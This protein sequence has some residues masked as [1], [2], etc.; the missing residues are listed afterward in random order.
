MRRFALA[1]V[2]IVL[3]IESVGPAFA[4]RR[5]VV[6]HRPHRA[7]VVIHRGFPLHRRLPVVV[8]RPARR[9]VVVRPAVFLAPVV[10]TAGVVALPPRERLGWE[11]SEM[12]ARDDDW[13]EFTLHVGDRGSKLFL[14]LL[15]RTQLNFAEV[16]YENGD[17]QV[18]DFNEKT[19]G[20]GIYSLLDFPDGRKVS[21]VRMVARAR[22]DEA[23]VTLRM[24]K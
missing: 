11:D 10:W 13:T 9:A 1:L 4:R 12:L 18:V 14:E 24:A 16:V 23:K 15:G 22:S 17:A 2:L 7:A 5:V 6:R 20:P 19:R 8:V 3:A 21:H